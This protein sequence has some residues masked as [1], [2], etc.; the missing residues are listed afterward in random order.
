MAPQI[1]WGMKSANAMAV[2]P[3]PMKY[4]APPSPKLRLDQIEDDRADDRAL[5]GAEAADQHHEEH[6][7]GPLDTEHRAGLDEQRVGEVERPG[8]A[9]ADRRHNEQD[10]L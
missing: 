2:A 5:E 9:A 4:Q 8:D 1:P 10:S 7:G 3:R 6:V